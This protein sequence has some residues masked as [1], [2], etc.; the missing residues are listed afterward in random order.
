M[1]QVFFPCPIYWTDKQ[2][3]MQ[4]IKNLPT[5]KSILFISGSV[6]SNMLRL[7]KVFDE[8][9][10]T[11]Q[12]SMITKTKNIPTA[13]E[14]KDIIDEIKERPDVIVAV[15]GGSS[16]DIA[17]MIAA[18]WHFKGR[19]FS[20][21]DI[22]M[23]VQT[24]E[25]LKYNSNIN[26][27]AVPTTAGT[28]SEVTSWATLWDTSNFKKYSVDADYL[29]PKETFMIPEFTLTMPDRLT[30]ATGLDAL[31]HATESYWAKDSNS[32]T[33]E[34]SK[35]AIKLIVNY[36]PKV[37]EDRSNIY[38][39]KKMA[40]GSLYAGVAFSQTRTTACHSIS[41]PLTM[42]Y[43]IEHGF[44]CALTLAEIFKLNKEHIIELDELLEAFNIK[45][46]DELQ[47]W[48]HK[49]TKNIVSLNLKGFNIKEEE[50]PLIAK[51]SFTQGRMDNNPVSLSEEDVCVLLSEIWHS[52]SIS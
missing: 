51:M 12:V 26:I 18:F 14:I 6:V 50:I 9:K 52:H 8:F 39:R 31:C 7:N 22:L 48:L 34:L 20:V 28:G 27:I 46:I 33:R 19:A 45:D 1:K 25:Y 43:G 40:L 38:F 32:I 11:H 36:L 37:L 17:K 47:V 10:S 41:Y 30:L 3:W 5:E 15:G 21:E 29:Y 44:A 24:K 35:V 16:I 23:Y 49:V 42:K 13:K 2:N 4:H